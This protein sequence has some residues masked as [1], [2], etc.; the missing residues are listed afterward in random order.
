[1]T[2]PTAAATAATGTTVAVGDV[3]ASITTSRVRGEQTPAYAD[4][5]SSSSAPTGKGRFDNPRAD[6]GGVMAERFADRAVA[7]DAGHQFV[8]GT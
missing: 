7:M 2:A 4:T 3:I 6:A 1:M 8:A 5:I